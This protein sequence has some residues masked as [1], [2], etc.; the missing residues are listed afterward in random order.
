MTTKFNDGYLLFGSKMSE[1][2]GHHEL[3]TVHFYE[4]KD[5]ENNLELPDYESKFIYQKKPIYKSYKK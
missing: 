1:K 4:A 5:D 2:I 3:E